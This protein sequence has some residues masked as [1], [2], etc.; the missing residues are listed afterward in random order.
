MKLER[1]MTYDDCIEE[2]NVLGFEPHHNTD[3]KKRKLIIYTPDYSA[4]QIN[5]IKT[6][7]NMNT[8]TR[9]LDLEVQ[10]VFINHQLQ[11]LNTILGSL[12]KE[13]Q[14]IQNKDIILE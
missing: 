1:Y 10:I 14:E 8:E 7:Y 12:Q 5:K 2:I 9:L 6:T 4:P 11:K 3:Y 13:I